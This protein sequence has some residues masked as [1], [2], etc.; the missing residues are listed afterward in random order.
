MPLCHYGKRFF[1]GQRRE[2]AKQLEDKIQAHAYVNSMPTGRAC[3]K[4]YSKRFN[5]Q[6]HDDVF[7]I[8]F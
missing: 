2:R 4:G 1:A 7:C 5:S 8:I 3:E 6:R